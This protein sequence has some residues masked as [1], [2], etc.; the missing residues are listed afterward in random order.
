MNKQSTEEF[1]KHMQKASEG[2]KAATEGLADAS[3]V[4]DKKGRWGVFV[5]VLSN[6]SLSCSKC[7]TKLDEV[8]DYLEENELN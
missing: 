6:L 8:M 7:K 3:K 2:L 5:G 1:Q 4:L